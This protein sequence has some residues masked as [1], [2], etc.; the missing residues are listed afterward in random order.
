MYTSRVD[1]SSLFFPHGMKQYST[2]PNK[3]GTKTTFFPRFWLKIYVAKSHKVR[4]CL[5]IF[6]ADSWRSAQFVRV[7]LCVCV[8][9][10]LHHFKINFRC[11][12][13]TQNDF[14]LWVRFR[15]SVRFVCSFLVISPGR[16]ICLSFCSVFQVNLASVFLMWYI[17]E[18]N[19]YERMHYTI[20]GVMKTK[21]K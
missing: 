12:T 18:P 5:S 10:T 14:R 7:L 17:Y 15:C 1:T 6:C 4:I 16:N 9:R 20:D 13:F 21:R 11:V 8:Y 3:S 2:L 19:I